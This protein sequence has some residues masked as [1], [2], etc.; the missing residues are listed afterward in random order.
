MKAA[1]IVMTILGCDDSV[2]QCHYIA[3]A[4]GQWQTV[5]ACD[6]QSE[7]K[8][9]A[10]TKSSYP[11]I[12]AVCETAGGADPGGAVATAPEPETTPVPP[13]T[14]PAAHASADERPGSLPQRALALVSGALPD[15]ERLRHGI[16]A[17]VD[18]IEAGYTWVVRKLT[19]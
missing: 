12:V 15:M 16:H 8:L 5:A 19:P 14:A 18:R 13:A 7:K 2:S 1:L 3:T 17:R 6:A 11:V 4:D 9:P 10:Y